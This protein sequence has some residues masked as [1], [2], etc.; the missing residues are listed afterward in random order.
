MRTQLLILSIITAMLLGLLP[1]SAEPMEVSL[2]TATKG[3]GFQL[4]GNAAAA[5]INDSDPSL[6]VVPH[7]TKGSLENIPLLNDGKFDLG[8]VQGVAAYEAFNGIGQPAV[9]L[10]VVA[11][12]YS[13]PGMFV[14]KGDSAAQSVVDLVG[15]PV[16]WGTRTSGLT[17]MAKYIMDGLGYDRDKDF[18]PVFL[19]KAGEGPPLVIDGKVDAFWGAGIGWPGFTKVMKSGGRFIGFTD[20]DVEKVTA[21]HSFLK[22]MT[23]PA[24][25]YEGQSEDVGS[26]GVWSFI[27]SRPDLPDDVAYKVAK[28]LYQGHDALA[29]KLPQA[30]ETTPENTLSSVD[31]GRIHPGVLKYLEEIGLR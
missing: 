21:K 11:A 6:K 22:A 7:D 3:G 27:L 26:I 31:N 2:A 20:N 4:Y 16:A 29:A 14:V 12:I 28:A 1:A 15:K 5:A 18:D 17:L 19:K 13:S 24:D 30:R 9:D 10:K 25:S 8:L 23:V